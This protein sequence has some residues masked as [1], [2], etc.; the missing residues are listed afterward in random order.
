MA[1]KTAFE[2]FISNEIE[3]QKGLYIPIKASAMERL[4]VKS[5]DPMTLHPNPEDEFCF[6]EIGPS[7]KIIS[8]Y[9]E[10][11]QHRQRQDAPPFDEPVIVEKTRPDGYMLLNGHHRWAA[12]LRL[13]L[14]K[15][16]IK[17]VNLAL[18][19]DIKTML[20]NSKHDKRVTIDLDEVLFLPE[21][22]PNVETG[23]AFSEAKQKVRLR[24]GVPALFHYLTKKGYDIWVYSAYYYS[25]DDIKQFFGKYSVNVDGIITGTG[26][27]KASNS[28]AS[29]KMEKLISNKYEKTIHIDNESLILTRGQGKDFEER[30]IEAESQ[31]WAK[32]VIDLIG[33]LD[34]NEESE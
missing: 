9:V 15:I 1:Q 5:A 25:I 34:R 7:Y 4:M 27:R 19:S 13:G 33:E 12:A 23:P 26:K 18:E 8:E 20:E 17:I 31:N 10:Q 24:L 32:K 14:K 16:P 21:K 6:P 28:E 22:D 11:I 29:R 2:E 3:K 30:E